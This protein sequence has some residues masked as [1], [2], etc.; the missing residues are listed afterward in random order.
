MNNKIIF[1]ESEID[2]LN[3]VGNTGQDHDDY[4]EPGTHPRYDWMR[5]IVLGLLSYQASD[6]EPNEHR[7][8]TIWFDLEHMQYKCQLGGIFTDIA[9]AIEILSS[10]LDN[11]SKDVDEKRNRFQPTSCFSGIARIETNVISIPQEIQHT[12]IAPNRPFLFKNGRLINPDL[13]QFNTGCPVAIELS[14]DAILSPN[15]HFTIF[16]KQ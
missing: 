11:W 7:P 1:P 16:I 9:N 8:G 14:K 13:V 2:F 6:Q 10:N 5:M 3:D 15:Q 12:A 4:A